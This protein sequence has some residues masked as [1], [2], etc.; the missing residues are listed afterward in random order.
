ML[1]KRE[2]GELRREIERKIK[3][4]RERERERAGLTVTKN[5]REKF[6]EVREERNLKRKKN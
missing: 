6:R 5:K 4:E 2:E 3:R 1:G